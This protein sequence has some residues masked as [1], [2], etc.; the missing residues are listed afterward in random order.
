[1]PIRRF[2][3]LFFL[4]LS[5]LRPMLT[6][7]SINVGQLNDNALL[8]TPPP[9]THTNNLNL[10]LPVEESKSSNQ[11]VTL[12][13]YYMSSHDLFKGPC[14]L[15]ER[16]GSLYPGQRVLEL[17]RLSGTDALAGRKHWRPFSDIWKLIW[18]FFMTAVTAIHLTWPEVM[19]RSTENVYFLPGN[20][21][22]NIRTLLWHQILCRKNAWTTLLPTR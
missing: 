9:H 12:W 3:F 8:C 18:I 2:S 7:A 11:S 5:V 15:G 21:H 16:E 4:F 17:H 10:V 1:M 22:P 19:L 6:R 14:C 20:P 13:S